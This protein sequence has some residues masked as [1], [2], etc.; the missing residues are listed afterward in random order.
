[1][2]K[3]TKLINAA[4]V[5][6]LESI[7]WANGVGRGMRV[8]KAAEA[9]VEAGIEWDAETVDL[10]D[11]L[12]AAHA[13]ISILSNERPPLTVD[14]L[15]ADDVTARTRAAIAIDEGGARRA[16]VA[17]QQLSNAAVHA[18]NKAILTATPATLERAVAWLIENQ[19]ARHLAHAAANLPRNIARQV[20]AWG[21]A[22]TAHAQLLILSDPMGWED[23][24]R[25]DGLHL[26]YKW[27]DEQL[28]AL[29]S[30]QDLLSV[31]KDRTVKF[32]EHWVFPDVEF[33]PVATV[34]E[35]AAR[36]K[37]GN[38]LCAAYNAE[39]R[40]REKSPW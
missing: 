37:A 27:T 11:R 23:L 14:D 1:M 9:T 33:S 16:T 10:I 35:L 18:M 13:Q 8:G 36:T 19:T 15:L 5:R 3:N 2:S 26:H 39:H 7:T 32:K 21:A 40:A 24:E 38:D 4:A 20:T 34:A 12:A 29:H 25:N 17:Q 28:L 31:N 22:A 30:E 6:R